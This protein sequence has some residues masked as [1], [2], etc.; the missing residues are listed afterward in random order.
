MT[1]QAEAEASTGCP[2]ALREAA[3][4]HRVGVFIRIGNKQG[5][6]RG[7]GTITGLSQLRTL[8]IKEKLYKS[9]P[10]GSL[11]LEGLRV[12]V[13]AASLPLRFPSIFMPRPGRQG[14]GGSSWDTLKPCLLSPLPQFPHHRLPITTTLARGVIGTAEIFVG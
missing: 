3:T 5:Q 11:G 8:D 14:L 12:A 13:L 6:G 9:R 10:P 1:F 7:G 2:E 4:C